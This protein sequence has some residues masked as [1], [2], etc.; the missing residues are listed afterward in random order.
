MQTIQ[1]HEFKFYLLTFHAMSIIYED[2]E[3]IL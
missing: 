3:L 1:F 2:N